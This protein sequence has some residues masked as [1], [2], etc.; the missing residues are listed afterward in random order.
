MTLRERRETKE[1]LFNYLKSF[2]VD[3]YNEWTNENVAEQVKAFF[4]TLCF[5]GN[6]FADTA[7]CDNML[8]EIYRE[9]NCP[10][11]YDS[12]ENFMIELIV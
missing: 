5:V 4:T 9:S 12:F 7:E 2:V 11:S 3:E 6:V 10:M 8:S 1:A